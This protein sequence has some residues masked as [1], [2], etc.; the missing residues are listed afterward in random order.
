MK[1]R[2]LLARAMVTDPELLILDEPTA[3]VD[4]QLRRDLWELITELNEAGTTILLTTHYIEEAE[5]LCD[6]VAIMDHGQKVEVA[7]PDELRD[8]GT[9]RIVLGLSDALDDHWPREELTAIEGVESVEVE[10]STVTVRARGAGRVAPPLLNAIEA[11]GVEVLD[12]D[13]E[14]ASLEE[15]FVE[16]TG[17]GASVGRAN[18][19]DT[20]GE[21]R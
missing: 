15:I 1:R 16:L 3:G 17:G 6:R 8:R 11:T 9:D 20:E 14:R 12:I 5:R 13:I 7:T 2:F 21:D 4:V 19:T 10:D 18:E